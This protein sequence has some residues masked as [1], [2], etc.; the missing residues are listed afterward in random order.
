MKALALSIHLIQVSSLCCVKQ[1]FYRILR[2]LYDYS[3]CGRRRRSRPLA[4]EISIPQLSFRASFGSQKREIEAKSPAQN[5]TKDL[6]VQAV[7]GLKE[8][9][10]CPNTLY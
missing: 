1:D 7:C 6:Q 10:E 8:I 3:A 4:T 9:S 2:K 5:L